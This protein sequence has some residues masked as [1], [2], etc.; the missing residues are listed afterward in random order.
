[1]KFSVM[2]SRLNKFTGGHANIYCSSSRRISKK[3]S[4]QE[5]PKKDG[6]KESGDYDVT[7]IRN[8]QEEMC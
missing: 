6:K 7:Y 8:I 3:M 5:E 1:M 4:E 2:V